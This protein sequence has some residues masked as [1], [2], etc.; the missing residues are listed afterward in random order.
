MDPFAGKL[1]INLSLEKIQAVPLA[2]R[3]KIS[4]FSGIRDY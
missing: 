1:E 4:L 2:C 3:K